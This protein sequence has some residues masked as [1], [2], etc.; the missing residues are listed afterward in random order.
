MNVADPTTFL[1]VKYT[2]F[3]VTNTF[4][5]ADDKKFSQMRILPIDARNWN[6]SPPVY[7]NVNTGLPITQLCNLDGT[8]S[9]MKIYHSWI[10]VANYTGVADGGVVILSQYFP[11]DGSWTGGALPAGTY[12]LR[13]DTLNYDGSISGPGSTAV[14]PHSC[15]LQ[16]VLPDGVTACGGCTVG[17]WGDMVFKTPIS[18]GTF[19]MPLFQVPPDYAGETVTIDIF[20]PGDISGVGDVTMSIV[21]PSG[22]VATNP[23]GIKIYDMGVDRSTPPGTLIS[24]Q[25]DLTKASFVSTLAGTRCY[26]GHWI[27]IDLPIPASYSP[28]PSWWWQL[29]YQ[30]GVATTADDTVTIA[31]SL[32]GSPVHL[33]QS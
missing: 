12:R 27:H 20:D 19:T 14:G 5:R 23:A 2:I 16:V 6:L 7:T 8:P 28:G 4:V 3:K 10:D 18:G 9:N 29:Q 22:V 25:P 1:S 31:V 33:L 21:D 30:T 26:N 15:A 17:G 11:A 32:K 24:T 13:A